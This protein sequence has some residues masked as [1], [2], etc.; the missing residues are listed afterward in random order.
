[1]TRKEYTNYQEYVNDRKYTSKEN[2]K[3]NEQSSSSRNK[4]L[5]GKVEDKNYRML[6]RKN[7]SDFSIINK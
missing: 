7:I 1:M 4:A 5:N 2:N 6:N 3:I